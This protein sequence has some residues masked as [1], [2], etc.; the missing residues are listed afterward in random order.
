MISK[1]RPYMQRKYN[2]LVALEQE[3]DGLLKVE[4]KA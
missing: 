3:S 1:L 4:A 2:R